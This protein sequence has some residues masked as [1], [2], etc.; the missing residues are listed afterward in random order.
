MGGNSMEQRLRHALLGS[1]ERITKLSDRVERKTQ[2][3]YNKNQLNKTYLESI[4]HSPCCLA[5]IPRP[6]NIIPIN[7][8]TSGSNL[9][10]VVLSKSYNHNNPALLGKVHVRV[11]NRERDI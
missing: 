11:H 1:H 9:H 7:R 6:K 2:I 4:T 8:K 3:Q 5:L 10:P